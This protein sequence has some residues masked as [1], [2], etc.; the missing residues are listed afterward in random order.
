MNTSSSTESSDSYAQLGCNPS[1]KSIITSHVRLSNHN[2]LRT[3]ERHMRRN[4]GG[5]VLQVPRRIEF[6]ERTVR[7][8]TIE[9]HDD[10]HAPQCRCAGG[11]EHRAVRGRARHDNRFYASIGQNLIKV[12]AKELIHSRF[13][14]RF[15]IFG[16]QWFYRLGRSGPADAVSD[17]YSVSP[18]VGKKTRDEWY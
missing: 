17:Q 3:R 2:Q 9:G 16:R 7:R 5:S 14:S 13:D 10:L 15:S 6:G 18:R 12:R 11:I 1:R 4:A 8:I